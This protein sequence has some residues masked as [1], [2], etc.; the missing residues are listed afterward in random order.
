MNGVP[1]R[2]SD[3]RISP[4]PG[5]KTKNPLIG[6]QNGPFSRCQYTKNQWLTK[7]IPRL[8]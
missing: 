5:K 1:L 4:A 6:A 7:A 8:A 3:G 2:Q